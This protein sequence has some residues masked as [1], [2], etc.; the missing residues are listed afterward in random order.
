MQCGK[1]DAA[2]L[3]LGARCAE[4]ERGGAR[5]ATDRSSLEGS[6]ARSRGAATSPGRPVT[7]LHS[8]IVGVLGPAIQ[9][10]Q[11]LTLQDAEFALGHVEPDAVLGG[12]VDL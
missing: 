6:V 5:F 4:L 7:S 8:R 10:I 11:I 1:L 9:A 2:R 3:Q 12:V